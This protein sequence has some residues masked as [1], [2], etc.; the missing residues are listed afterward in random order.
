MTEKIA[1]LHTNDLHSHFENWPKVRHY[2]LDKRAQLRKQGYQVYTVDVGD[3][4]DRWHPLTDATDGQANIQQLNRIHYTAA[5]IGNNEGL[6][7]PHHV[8]DHLYD[9]A[10]FP[11]ILDNLYDT[12]TN[13][14]PKW[15]QF[16]K[17]VKTKQGTRIMFVG[18]TVPYENGYKFL[19]WRATDYK[20]TVPKI[21]NKVKGKYDFLVLLSHLG[22]DRDRY[23]AKHYPEFNLI[24]GGHTHHLFPRGEKDNNSLLVAAKKYGYYVGCATF[25]LQNHKIVNEKATTVRTAD[26]PSQKGDYAEIKDYMDRGNQLLTDYKVAEIPET[27]HAK[28]KEPANINTVGLKAI[29]EATHT[30]AAMISTGMFLNSIPKG[31]VNMRQTHNCLP[32]SIFP[33]SSLMTGQSLW[34]LVKEVNKSRGF[35]S[36]YPMKGMGFRGKIFGY[37]RF[38][39]IKYDPKTEIVYYCGKP[40]IPSKLYKIGMLDHYMFI[41]FFPVISIM[42]HNHIFHDK[43]LRVIFAE[44]LHRHYPLK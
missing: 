43:F 35:L 28:L 2:L 30:H 4:I 8:L 17:V 18:L 41:P 34:M 38:A 21:L 16:D 11:V 15:S 12:K 7:N 10:N 29:M 42:G 32:H 14:R 6:N 3:A 39:G 23:I 24:V 19:N 33:M 5:T 31:I 40:V 13:Q 44:Y 36:R 1:F 37:V 20:K 9:H 25:E 22:V 26:L 27:L